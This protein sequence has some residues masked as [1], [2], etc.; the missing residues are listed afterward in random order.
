MTKIGSE[1]RTQMN[2]LSNQDQIPVIIRRKAGMLNTQAVPSSAQIDCAFKLF[3]AE[4]IKITAA[5]IENLGKQ[6]DVEQIWPDLPIQA[7]LDSSAPKISMP[8]VRELGLKGKGIKVAIIDTGIDETHPDFGGRIIATKSFV[9][10]SA[11]DDN[12]HG[13]HVAGVVAGSGIKSNGKYMGIAPEANLYIGKVLRANGSGLMSEVMAGI[14][15]AVLE[16]QVQVINLS[17]G[18]AVSCDGTDAL[19]VLC[20]EAVL[21]ADI[22][23]CIAAGNSGPT[24]RTIGS[25]GCARYVI[26]VGAITDSDQIARFSS[27]GPTADG[28]IK[29]DIVYPG[30]DII[31]PQ[32]AGTQ[33]G[34]VVRAGYVTANGT[35]MAAPHASGVAALMLEAN[36]KLTAER[37]KNQMLA[38]AVSIGALP[39]TQGIGRGDAYGA[40]QKA[41]EQPYIPDPTPTLPQPKP[42]QASGCLASLAGLFSR[43]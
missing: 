29:P 10:G 38:G 11:R 9:G 37:T 13:T 31:A 33:M 6:E 26:T 27:R 32:A 28:R 14:E 23:M 5:D 12:G 40:Y 42:S 35:S 4:A 34:Q 43:K 20:D 41:I 17:L 1:L 15:W 3:P 24:E 39:N 36:P 21:Q 18:G 16:Q 8:K 19:S 2:T 22:V 25:P 7:C 30:V